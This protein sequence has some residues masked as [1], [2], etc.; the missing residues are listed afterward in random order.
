MKR[1]KGDITCD[2]AGRLAPG[3]E[4]L[5]P[6]VDDTTESESDKNTYHDVATRAST[7]KPAS[8]NSINVIQSRT[9]EL[10]RM[11]E[12]N[13]K[14]NEENERLQIKLAKYANGH[15]KM[16]EALLS[17]DPRAPVP[18]YLYDKRLSFNH[19]SK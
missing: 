19:L 16:K 9:R 5:Y 3:N 10:D 13:R 1:R 12:L 17:A 4:F 2:V 14:M 11:K 8:F 7:P 18:R 6:A 15:K